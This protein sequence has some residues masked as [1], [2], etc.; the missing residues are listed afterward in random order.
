MNSI[1]TKERLTQLYW[2]EELSQPEIVEQYGV[3]RKA[4][5][6]WFK[7]YEIPMRSTGEASRVAIAKGRN[8]GAYHRKL[9]DIPTEDLR[10]MYWDEGL[11]CSD[12]AVKYNVEEHTVA[13][14]FT[15]VGIP[16]RTRSDQLKLLYANGKMNNKEYASGERSYQWK[17]GRQLCKGYIRILCP[18]HHRAVKGYVLE[19]IV[20]WEQAHGEE[21]PDGWVV[22]HLNGIKDD[23]RPENLLALPTSRHD[24]FIPALKARIR[25]LETQLADV[26][27]ANGGIQRCH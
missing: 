18:E 3:S 8:R 2:D 27:N 16:K 22:H 17:G 4:L 24:N 9:E 10:R 13:N 23:N 11:S 5:Q 25:E 6:Y 12:I 26:L 7:K 21:L 19:H 14:Y 1:F 20:V 15:H